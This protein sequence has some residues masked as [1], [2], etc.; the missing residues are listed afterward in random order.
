[1]GACVV[2]GDDPRA[3]EL[4]LLD[5]AAEADPNSSSF[6][7]LLKALNLSLAHR[8]DLHQVLAARGWRRSSQ[9]LEYVR[10]KVLSPDVWEKGGR[11]PVPASS[12]DFSDEVSLM[13]NDDCDNSRPSLYAMVRPEFRRTDPTTGS[14]AVR[15]DSIAEKLRL[16]QLQVKALR[17]QLDGKDLAEALA[18]ETRADKRRRLT[19]AWMA[20]QDRFPDI[21]KLILK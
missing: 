8:G 12:G 4:Q 17:L 15:W 14:T 16:S 10:R 19:A 5:D 21:R 18:Q 2:S 7:A 1:M 3:L 20:L 6:E 11:V 9:P 13:R